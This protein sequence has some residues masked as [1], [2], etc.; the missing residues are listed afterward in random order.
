MD[1]EPVLVEGFTP[2]D[3]LREELQVPFDP[4]EPPTPQMIHDNLEFIGDCRRKLERK[5]RDL[6]RAAYA[7][8]ARDVAQGAAEEVVSNFGP[9]GLIRSGAAAGA[10]AMRDHRLQTVQALEGQDFC[11][12]HSPNVLETRDACGT[13]IDY[14]R[15]KVN[16]K[17]L[18]SAA[19]T[20]PFVGYAE[21]VR[22]IAKA[23][24]KKFKHTKGIN[25]EQHSNTLFEAIGGDA[26]LPEGWPANDIEG[27]ANNRAYC[28]KARAAVSVLLT[29]DFKQLDGWLTVIALASLKLEYGS[30]LIQ[31]KM[32]ST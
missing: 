31:H 30:A 19:S 10:A 8:M 9:I 28:P 23:G 29:G 15:R 21:T 22:S 12:C 11:R 6:E 20:I 27:Y 1:R 4:Q 25:R 3:H 14:A 5:A 18:R 26:S 7:G 13:A 24:Y 17:F 32:A 2:P 16:V